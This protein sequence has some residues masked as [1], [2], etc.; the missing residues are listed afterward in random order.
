MAITFSIS[1]NSRE[2]LDER[3]RPPTNSLHVKTHNRDGLSNRAAMAHQ[4][5]HRT[6]RQ[7][8]TNLA[9]PA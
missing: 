2:N 4:L 9:D 6:R 1:M 7:T 5:P 8:K 3:T